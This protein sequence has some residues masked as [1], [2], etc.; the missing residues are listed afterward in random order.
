[1]SVIAATPATVTAAAVIA[2]AGST[3]R[4]PST[5]A[6]HETQLVAYYQKVKPENVANVPS[7]FKKHGQAIWAALE[8]KTPGSTA[9]FVKV[10]VALH[11][12]Y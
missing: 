8:K 10:S 12:V 5:A 2:T 9:E 4:P 7:L 1:V 3:G 11:S 6:E